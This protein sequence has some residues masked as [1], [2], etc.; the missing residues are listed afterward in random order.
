MSDHGPESVCRRGDPCDQ[1][2]GGPH[3][4]GRHLDQRDELYDGPGLTLSVLPVRVRESARRLVREAPALMPEVVDLA[5]EIEFQ[6]Q[7]V[8]AVRV[9]G[10]RRERAALLLSESCEHHGRMIEELG[11]Q[12]HAM[13][14][15]QNRTEAARVV[16]VSFLQAVRELTTAYQQG[17]T[18]GALTIDTVMSNLHQAVGK[19]SAAHDRAWKK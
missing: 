10:E 4:A 19:T 8:A 13:D 5:K 17:R 12:V 15:A 11:Q 14:Q 1:M 6:R 2:A 3:K 18:T 16:L 9:D 7:Q